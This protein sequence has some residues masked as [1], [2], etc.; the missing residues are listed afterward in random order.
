MAHNKVNR[1]FSYI[2]VTLF[3]L[4][5]TAFG[6]LFFTMPKLKVSEYEKRPL[7]QIPAFS[8]S[9][10]FDG[11]YLDSLDKYYA[12]NFPLRENFVALNFDLKEKRGI[13]SEDVGFIKAVAIDRQVPI[14]VDTTSGKTDSTASDSIV[15]VGPAD[16]EMGGGLLIYN[17]HCMEVFGGSRAMANSY[18]SAVNQYATLLPALKIYCVC[19]P[20]SIAFNSNEEYRKNGVAEQTNINQ[21]Y[22]SLNPSV[23]A[24][25]A[26]SEIAA[27]KN[28]YIYFRTDHHWTGLGAYYAYVATLKRA[29]MTPIALSAMTHKVKPNYLGSL[30]YIT[31]DSRLKDFPDSVEYWMV[32]G[33]HTTL[34]YGESNTKAFAS[35]L[36]AEGAK[37]GNSYGV[38]LGGDNPLMRIDN[39]DISNGRRICIVKNSYG[40]PY[41]T[42]FTANFERV[43]VVDYRYYKGSI[44]DLIKDEGI[45]DLV[46]INGIFS[47]NTSW[48]IKMM[49]K[50]MKAQVPGKPKEPK[51]DSASS[52]ADSSKH[53]N[54]DSLK[55]KS[56]KKI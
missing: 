40:N 7:A 24:V 1:T 2:N 52:P 37:G 38:F 48:H 32:P 33:R 49:T 22:S 34:R 6:I 53:I 5:L 12:D 36:Y 29:G 46:F 30:Y 42:Y 9:E 19:V 26:F 13:R 50:I 10:F 28:E 51:S 43:F 54:V 20:S 11:K 45:T 39:P 17:Q 55:K 41:S 21:I 44:M 4:A 27:H 31:H 14:G 15:D 16:T 8:W 3:T 35:S 25:D 56:G 18:A 23:I 47:A